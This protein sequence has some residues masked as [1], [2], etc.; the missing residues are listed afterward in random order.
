MTHDNNRTRL[1]R[2][3]DLAHHHAQQVAAHIEKY[4][5][6]AVQKIEENSTNVQELES[7]L[8]LYGTGLD[9]PVNGVAESKFFLVEPSWH[10]VAHVL[11]TEHNVSLT[12]H[13]GTDDYTEFEEVRGGMYLPIRLSV[14]KDNEPVATLF[15]AYILISAELESEFLFFL[16][17]EE[18]HI[19]EGLE[20]EEAIFDLWT[21]QYG[22]LSDL[23]A[24]TSHL[25]ISEDR[26]RSFF[27]RRRDDEVF[28]NHPMVR[29]CLAHL[30]GL[31]S[32]L[33]R[34]KPADAI[35]EICRGTDTPD[36]RH[37]LYLLGYAGPY[38]VNL[39]AGPDRVHEVRA[40]LYGW[41]DDGFTL[42]QG[43]FF[44][45]M[46][47]AIRRHLAENQSDE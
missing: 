33:R 19:L 15:M 20:E 34:R 40:K 3:N 13:I 8:R 24:D 7:D 25:D 21:G 32:L 42:P 10:E 11:R 1:P 26:L 43:E 47:E 35:P 45:K 22:D 36:F 14:T 17:H 28:R 30:A 23:L 41:G 31:F 9:V 4:F 18:G 37:A 5:S 6:Q 38:T 39:E 16:G 2:D 46:D 29:E 12:E 44:D 27:Q